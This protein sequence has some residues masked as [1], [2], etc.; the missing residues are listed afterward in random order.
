MTGHG[1]ESRVDRTVRLAFGHAQARLALE[2]AEATILRVRELHATVVMHQLC[3]D[4]DC[5]EEH[6]QD[7]DGCRVHPRSVTTAYCKVCSTA[8]LVLAPCLTIRA[9]NQPATAEGDPA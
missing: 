9:L 8:D 2:A 6:G 3:E 4:G 7:P 5:P 1:P